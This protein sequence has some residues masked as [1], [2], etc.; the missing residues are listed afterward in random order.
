MKVCLGKLVKKVSIEFQIFNLLFEF[1]NGNL[2]T[3]A[4]TCIICI[5]ALMPLILLQLRKLFFSEFQ[6]LTY[7]LFKF[8]SSEV[9]SLSTFGDFALGPLQSHLVLSLA[10]AWLLVFFGVFK[11]LGS[12]A[13]TMNVT[14]TV[15]YLL[16]K[17]LRALC[18][19]RNL[20]T[21]ALYSSSS[22]NQ[23]SRCQQRTFISFHCRFHKTLEMANLEIGSWTSVLW[24]WNRCGTTHF[25]GCFLE[26]SQ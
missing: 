7:R 15:P 11:G 12:I 19:L 22:W 26:I 5:V 9:L 2:T 3:A 4:V 18:L 16:V 24:T 1:E 25:D 23:S 14:A 13:Q 6:L 8:S 20:N 21:S 10:A 17:I